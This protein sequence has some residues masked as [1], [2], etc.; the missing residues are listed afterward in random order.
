MVDLPGIAIK[1]YY[2]DNSKSKLYIHDHFGPKVEMPVSIYFREEEDF[3]LLERL[4]LQNCQGSILDIGAGAGSHA[5][6]LQEKG[7]DVTALEI[8]ES[9][10]KIMQER[11]VKKVVCDDFFDAKLPLFDTLLL[12]MNGIG[13]CGTI[14]KIPVFLQKAHSLLKDNGKIIFDSSDI[15]YMYED[16]PL[17]KHYYGEVQYQYAYKRMKTDWFKWLYIDAKTM[18]SIASENGWEMQVLF[19]DENDQYLASLTKK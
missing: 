15:K 5:L 17:P 13:L 12:L 18:Q 7:L 8:S 3:P 9:S 10:S 19:E 16:I 11:G 14:E 6:F 1:E 2:C 4:A